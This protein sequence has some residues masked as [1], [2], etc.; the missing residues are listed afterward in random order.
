MHLI[1]FGFNSLTINISSVVSSCTLFDIGSP[2]PYGGM[3][4]SI[5]L[6]EL[7]IELIKD[8]ATL[9]ATLLVCKA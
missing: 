2:I 1:I 7:V 5:E 4:V 6:C 9:L 3:S 8:E